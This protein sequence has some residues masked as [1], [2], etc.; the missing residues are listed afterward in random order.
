MNVEVEAK[1]GVGTASFCEG[2]WNDEM[3]SLLKYTNCGLESIF[4]SSIFNIS[5]KNELIISTEKMINDISEQLR[6]KRHSWPWTQQLNKQSP[7]KVHLVVGLELL[8]NITWSSQADSIYITV[9]ISCQ[10]INN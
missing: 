1:E 6:F 5:G 3:L 7:H 2:W 9:Y 8:V 4:P 10:E